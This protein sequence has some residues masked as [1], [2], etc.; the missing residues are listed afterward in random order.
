VKLLFFDDY[1]LGVV[2]GDNVV[3]VSDV[4][5]DVPRIHPQDLLRGVIERFAEFKPQLEAAARQGQGVPLS[6]VRI[7]PP[8]PKPTNVVCMSANYQEFG[9]WSPPP[10]IDCFRKS[11]LGL[12]GDGGTM[13]LFDVPAQIFEGEA[14]LALVIGK[15]ASN[16]SEADAMS[17]VFGY[18]NFIDGSARFAREMSQNTYYKMKARDTYTIMGPYL[19]TADEVADPMN[20]QVRQWNNGELKQDY[21]TSDMAYNISQCIAYIT[22]VHPMEAGDVIA[23]GTNHRG[24]HAYQDGD[25]IEQEIDGLGR[26]HINIRDDLKRRWPRETRGERLARG[27]GGPYIGNTPDQESGKYAPPKETATPA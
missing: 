4:V 17:Y 13:V 12:T 15:W 24:L 14:E 16:V 7:Q 8:V 23:F 25:K 26:L 5:K 27:L 9:T 11:P 6:Q 18:M 20:L 19:V 2:S 21:N 1:K 10:V 3:D 22:S